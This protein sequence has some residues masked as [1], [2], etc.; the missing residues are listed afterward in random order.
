[1]K[2]F[3]VNKQP[4]KIKKKYAKKIKKFLD[5]KHL[6]PKD[7]HRHIENEY[8]WFS[9]EPL[10]QFRMGLRE[11]KTNNEGYYSVGVGAT[12]YANDLLLKG[13]FKQ[14]RQWAAKGAKAW[15]TYLKPVKMRDYYNPYAWWAKC[16]AILGNEKRMEE[17]IRRGTKLCKKP[18][19]YHEFQEAIDLLKFS[20]AR[21]ALT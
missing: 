20:R 6:F 12:Q 5:Q 16:E 7:M 2:M 1:M 18:R 8:L 9:H 21:Q 17:C 15:A 11:V 19:T 3:S 14:A 4:I 10:K 13:Q